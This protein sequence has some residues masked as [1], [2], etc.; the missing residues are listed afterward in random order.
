MAKNKSYTHTYKHDTK[1]SGPRVTVH[2]STMPAPSDGNK[3]VSAPSKPMK[4]KEAA[5]WVVKAH[6]GAWKRLED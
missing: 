4:W 2:N 6:A 1:P 5:A 3:V